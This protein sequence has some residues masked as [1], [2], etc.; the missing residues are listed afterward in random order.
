MN[1]DK[2]TP[3]KSLRKRPGQ[4][5]EITRL[6]ES[7]LNSAQKKDW[8]QLNKLVLSRQELLSDYFEGELSAQQAELAQADISALQDTDKQIIALTQSNKDLLAEAMVQLQRG[9]NMTAQYRSAG[10]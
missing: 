7:M 4:W 3:A 6:S 9:K 2:Q 10:S 5:Q 8:E 1:Q